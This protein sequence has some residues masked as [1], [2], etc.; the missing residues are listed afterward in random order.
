MVGS[1]ELASSPVS[2]EIVSCLDSPT[3]PINAVREPFNDSIL[4]YIINEEGEGLMADIKTIGLLPMKFL[5]VKG[6][7]ETLE[8]DVFIEET[9]WTT[10]SQV[11]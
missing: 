4:V 7:P 6:Q 9:E 5:S 3:S 10:L 1:T 8:G 2:L 11:R